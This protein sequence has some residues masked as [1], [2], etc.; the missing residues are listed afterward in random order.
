LA[1]YDQAL[2]LDAKLASVWNN[3]GNVWRAK[4]EWQKALADYSRAIQ[5]DR[6]YAAAYLN[7]GAIYLGLNRKTEAQQDF[8]QA[9]KFDAQLEP[10]IERYWQKWQEARLTEVTAR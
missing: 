6:H 3:R 5:L 4:G 1:D 7:R 9:S 10:L 8:A 2:K